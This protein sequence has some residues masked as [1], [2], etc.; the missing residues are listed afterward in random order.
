M[1]Y[2]ILFAIGFEDSFVH[3]HPNNFD[4]DDFLRRFDKSFSTN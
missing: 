1:L 3:I 2:Y 4:A